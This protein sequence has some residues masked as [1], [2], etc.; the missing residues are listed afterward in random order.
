MIAP[1]LQV[2]RGVPAEVSK[3]VKEIISRAWEVKVVSDMPSPSSQ[4][5]VPTQIQPEIHSTDTLKRAIRR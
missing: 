4:D 5:A 2:S 3:R 1:I